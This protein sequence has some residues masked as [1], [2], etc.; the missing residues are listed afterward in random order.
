MAGV[1]V[2]EGGTGGRRPLDSD[3]NM[4]P[5]NDRMMCLIALLP[6]T[7]VWSTAGRVD[8]NAN[9]PAGPSTEGARP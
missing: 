8:A 9:V 2:D 7:A 3:S 4:V 5:M 1:S 6:L